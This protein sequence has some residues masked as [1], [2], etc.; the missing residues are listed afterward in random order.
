MTYLKPLAS[1]HSLSTY[2]SPTV[3]PLGNQKD[4]FP[5]LPCSSSQAVR[6]D[7]APSTEWLTHRKCISHS[8]GDKSRARGGRLGSWGGAPVPAGRWPPP[9]RVLTWGGRALA[10]LA[11]LIRG[12]VP[13][14]QG[15]ALLTSQN[16]SS[17]L[18]TLSL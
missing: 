7:R 13:L 10:P 8:S 14:D 12:T 5:S 18:K 4:T 15:L 9:Q 3:C 6:L 1:F 2:S 16:L 11:P 17:L